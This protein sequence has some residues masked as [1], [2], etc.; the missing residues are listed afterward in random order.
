MDSIGSEHEQRTRS[1][2]NYFTVTLALGLLAGICGV[3]PQGARR[4]LIA[5]ILLLIP[6]VVRRNVTIGE[7]GVLIGVLL[8][9]LCAAIVSLYAEVHRHDLVPIAVYATPGIVVMNPVT[10]GVP[11]AWPGRAFLVLFTYLLPVDLGMIVLH[12]L[13]RVKL[14][15]GL[16]AILFSDLAVLAVYPL[17][18][19]ARTSWRPVG[20]IPFEIF[21]LAM[22]TLVFPAKYLVLNYVYDPAGFWA[23]REPDW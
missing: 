17:S 22:L 9:P 15:Q 8:A 13:P 11:F 3:W 2:S 18:W 19:G 4:L 20:S 12:G 16:R 5:P 23:S 10:G 14:R 21:S 7:V 6:G 1:F